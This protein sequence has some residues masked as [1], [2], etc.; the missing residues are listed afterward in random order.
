MSKLPCPGGE[1]VSGFAGLAVRGLIV[2]CADRNLAREHEEEQEL[3]G[4][5]G[6]RGPSRQRIKIGNSAVGRSEHFDRCNPVASIGDSGVG[7]LPDPENS[8]PPP[9]RPG[10]RAPRAPRPGRGD[11]SN[12]ALPAEDPVRLRGA[13]AWQRDGLRA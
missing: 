9:W 1:V 13:G 10:V 8:G 4:V 3:P 2:D 5:L 12:E 6:S 7:A 11:V